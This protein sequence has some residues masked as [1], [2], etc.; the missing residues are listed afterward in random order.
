M[1]LRQPHLIPNLVLGQQVALCTANDIE[2][3]PLGMALSSS[4]GQE[5]EYT[6]Y[7]KLK[8][9]GVPYKGDYAITIVITLRRYVTSAFSSVYAYFALL[10]PSR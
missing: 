6:L 4:I 5:Y 9:H 10:K 3:G 8:Q 2:F 7:Q 1:W